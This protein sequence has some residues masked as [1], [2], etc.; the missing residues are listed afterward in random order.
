MKIVDRESFMDMEGP[1]LYSEWQ[2]PGQFGDLMI[3]YDRLS[4]GDFYCYTVKDA[5]EASGSSEHFDKMIEIEEGN[6]DQ[7]DIDLE[8]KQREALFDDDRR[9]CVWELDDVSQLLD[10]LNDIRDNLESGVDVLGQTETQ[11]S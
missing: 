1:L 8:V 4:S 3:R 9:Y 5:I 10:I 2:G 11:S 7:V 6:R